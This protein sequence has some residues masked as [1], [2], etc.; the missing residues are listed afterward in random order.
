MDTKLFK[1]SPEALDT[2]EAKSILQEA[3]DLLKIGRLVAMPTET[4]YGL[5]ACALDSVAVGRIFKAKDRPADNPLILHIASADEL[6]TIAAVVPDSAHRLAE[7]FWP[8]PLTMVLERRPEIPAICSA[9]LPTVAVRCPSHP[10]ARALIRA[11]GFPLAAPSANCSGRPSPTTADHVMA[12]LGGRIEAVIDGGSCAV[13]LE[14][15]V[16][17]PAGIPTILRPGGITPDQ[18]RAVLGEVMVDHAVL[19]PLT[20]NEHPQS[21]GMKYAHYAPRTTILL[22]EG[23]EQ[24]TITYINE[25]GQAHGDVCALCFDEMADAIRVP[26]VALGGR[27][28]LEAQSHR[29]FAALRQI[30]ELGCTVC[31]AVTPA[32]NGIG[33]AV[34]NRLLRAAGF[35]VRKLGGGQ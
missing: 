20:L 7:A 24:E 17:S 2:P 27:D 15:T 33:L 1:V 3:A 16:I 5:A 21:P 8:G 28:D 18:I 34:Y 22:I 23:G 12:D 6:D 11:A 14:S 35:Q 29:L 32:A 10:V 4:V 25:Q 19:E 26:K 31:Y 30:D 9:G 13:G